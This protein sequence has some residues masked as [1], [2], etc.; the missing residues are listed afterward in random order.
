VEYWVLWAYNHAPSW[1]R[2]AVDWLVSFVGGMLGVVTDVLRLNANAWRRLYSSFASLR[3]N[4]SKFAVQIPATLGW[5]R[6]VWVP[7]L[8]TLMQNALIGLI[9]T[10]ESAIRSAFRAADALIDRAWRA[11]VGLLSRVVDTLRKWAGEAVAAIWRVIPEPIR[12]AW[13]MLLDPRRLAEWIVSAL[14]FALLRLAFKE[15]ALI[16]RWILATGPRFT[17]WLAREM[18]KV[19]VRLI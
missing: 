10:I 4:L 9:R 8:V 3:Y 15:M 13:N 17:L 1:V 19:I 7:R 16:G 5:L 14:F 2:G 12:R 11:A 18:E 6:N